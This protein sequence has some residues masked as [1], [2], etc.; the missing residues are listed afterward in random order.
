MEAVGQLTGGIAHDFNNMLAVVLGGLELARRSVADDRT[1]A[2]RHIDNATEGANRAAALTRQLLAFSREDSL[3]PETIEAAA[4]IAGMSD[5]LD[6]TLGD[7]ITLVVRD[8]AAGAR[9]RADRVQLENAVINLAVNARDAMDGRGVLTIVTGAASLAAD[10]IGQCAAGDY[11]TIIVE[12]DGCGMTPDIADRV[13]EP[14]FTTKGIGKGTGL[15]LSQV[16]ALVRHLNGEIGI[17]STPGEGTSV[18]LYLPRTAGAIACQTP[19][20]APNVRL[21]KVLPIAPVTSAVLEILV[22]EDDPRVLTA[23]TGALEELGHRTIACD[24]PFATPGLLAA[25]PSIALIISDVLMP[26]QTGPE[27]IAALDSV[28]SHVAVLFVTGFAGDINVAQF[29]GHEVLRKPFTLN[30]LERA[31]A[32]AIAADRPAASGAIA[33]E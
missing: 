9:I 31:V 1:E 19:S 17:A 33:A 26:R 11:V 23:T 25:N 22:V 32:R 18:K 8:E 27:M 20:P 13:F 4:L 6:R 29:R 30:G 16:F 7:A 12:D 24:D 15:G 28:Y 5:M 2:L 14:F 10:E 21:G 3:K